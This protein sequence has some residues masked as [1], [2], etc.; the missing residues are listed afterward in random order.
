MLTL[1]FATYC[2]FIYGNINCKNRF[3]AHKWNLH[4]LCVLKW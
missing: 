3:F 2:K 1:V 4:E